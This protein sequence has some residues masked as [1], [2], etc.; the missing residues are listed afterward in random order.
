MCNRGIASSS[1][2]IAT[3][4]ILAIVFSTTFTAHSHA[5][6]MYNVVDLGSVID[7]TDPTDNRIQVPDYSK[8]MPKNWYYD[9]ITSSNSVA[10]GASIINPAT[11]TTPPG[12]GQ[13]GSEFMISNMN[14]NGTAIGWLNWFD[15]AAFFTKI[16]PNL[17]GGIWPN[18][19]TKIFDF[20]FASPFNIAPTAINNNNVMVG[21]YVT[22]SGVSSPFVYQITPS[23]LLPVGSM[24]Q[25]N[26]NYLNIKDSA[27]AINLNDMIPKNLSST[28]SITEPEAIDSAGNIL[29]F[30]KV[31]NTPIANDGSFK[32]AHL[33]IL[34][35]QTVA[36]PEP[37]TFFTLA[38][39]G[40][41]LLIHR[42][43]SNPRKHKSY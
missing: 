39:L 6:T 34:T 16:S 7:M 37:S 31:G 10:L 27:S 17:Y 8:M 20:S 2:A 1:R 29:A 13:A 25:S 14:S 43:K 32:G 5:S 21:V 15:P 9:F 4:S 30:G 35:P 19:T 3:F 41:S 28:I 18:T 11:F 12:V 40:G 33:F 24:N 22:N 36:V 38:F 42:R 26:Y 23:Q